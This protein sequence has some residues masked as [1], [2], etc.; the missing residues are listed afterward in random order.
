MHVEALVSRLRAEI[1]RRRSIRSGLYDLR[2]ELVIAENGVRMV[3][4]NGG[5]YTGA[6]G[7]GAT[8]D[9]AAA[10]LIANLDCLQAWGA[11]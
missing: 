5:R 9:E 1:A 7:S 2:P 10:N 11:L 6:D 3:I 4:T 8:A